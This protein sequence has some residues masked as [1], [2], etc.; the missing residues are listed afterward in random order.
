MDAGFRFACGT[1]EPTLTYH[2]LV[3]VGAHEP[4]AV[5]GTASS[6]VTWAV[7]SAE[8]APPGTTR[9]RPA[10][11]AP[12]QSAFRAAAVAPVSEAR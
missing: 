4:G 1:D 10:D 12:R 7:A 9:S 6:A 5:K 2:E 8:A 11:R 3:V